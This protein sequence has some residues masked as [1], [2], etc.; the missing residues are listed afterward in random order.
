MCNAQQ[1]GIPPGAFTPM[2]EGDRQRTDIIRQLLKPPVVSLPPA[3]A[4]KL[5]LCFD[6]LTYGL[7]GLYEFGH[8]LGD[9]EMTRIVH[10]VMYP[11]VFS[12]IRNIRQHFGLDHFG[13]PITNA[14]SA[15]SSEAMPE[16]V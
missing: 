9:G 11:A 15:A 2:C 16:G 1:E 5:Q 4:A 8:A 10:N 3:D 12:A 14:D 6:N 13:R 7:K